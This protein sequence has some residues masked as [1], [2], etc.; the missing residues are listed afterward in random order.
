MLL[1]L[2]LLLLLAYCS[3]ISKVMTHVSIPADLSTMLGC[4]CLPLCLCTVDLSSIGAILLSLSSNCSRNFALILIL[5]DSWLFHLIWCYL[6]RR[7]TCSCH[8]APT[9]NDVLGWRVLLRIHHLMLLHC[10]E[11]RQWTA[12]HEHMILLQNGRFTNSCHT[13]VMDII[14]IIVIVSAGSLGG[15]VAVGRHHLLLS[16]VFG[17]EFFHHEARAGHSLLFLRQSNIVILS[18]FAPRYFLTLTLLY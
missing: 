10:R 8:H 12:S 17:W 14:V 4:S 15:M 11:T 6:P 9:C 5:R 2:L 3:R 16:T 7:Q 18:S 1:L 13:I